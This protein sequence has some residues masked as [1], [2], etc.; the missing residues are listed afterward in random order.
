MTDK[1]IDLE[2][3]RIEKIETAA[4]I[5]PHQLVKLILAHM[6]SGE[7]KPVRCVFVFEEDIGNGSTNLESYRA[8][9]DRPGELALLELRKWALIRRWMQ[10]ATS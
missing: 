3:R 9:V 1:P 4:E 10:A 2:I 6:E 5:T 7:I 8:G